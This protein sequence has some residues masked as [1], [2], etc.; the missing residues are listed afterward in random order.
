MKKFLAVL[1]L[2]LAASLAHA[3]TINLLSGPSYSYQ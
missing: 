3:D 2:I 1:I